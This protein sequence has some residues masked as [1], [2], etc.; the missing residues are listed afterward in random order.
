M[1]IK[2][3]LDIH[4]SGLSFG[5]ELEKQEAACGGDCAGG[6]EGPHIISFQVSMYSWG[7]LI[8]DFRYQCIHP[9]HPY[10]VICWRLLLFQWRSRQHTHCVM[11]VVSFKLASARSKKG[12]DSEKEFS[13]TI[14]HCLAEFHQP[15][16]ESDPKRNDVSVDRKRA[17]KV[18]N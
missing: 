14:L 1:E 18:I 12:E 6:W 2:I 7:T 11:A 9:D 13:K 8:P 16:G 4:K 3:P 15:S 10:Y 17:S 5:D